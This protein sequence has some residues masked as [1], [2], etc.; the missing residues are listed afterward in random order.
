MNQAFIDLVSKIKER[1]VQSTDGDKEFEQIRDDLEQFDE[2]APDSLES[3]G[4]TP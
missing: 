2:R 3:P 4:R 1:A